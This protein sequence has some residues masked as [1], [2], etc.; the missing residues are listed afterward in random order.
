MFDRKEQPARAKRWIGE[1]S[2]KPSSREAKGESAG[3]GTAGRLLLCYPAVPRPDGEERAWAMGACHSAKARPQPTSPSVPDII[4]RRDRTLI[5]HQQAREVSCYGGGKARQVTALSAKA[6]TS[7]RDEKTKPEPQPRAPV[8]LNRSSTARPGLKKPEPQPRDLR[9]N[10]GTLGA[11]GQAAR[12]RTA[13]SVLPCLTGTLP[14][15]SRSITGHRWSCRS[16]PE[17]KRE[18]W[19]PA[20]TRI[21]LSSPRAVGGMRGWEISA[22]C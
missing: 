16:A 20:G 7:W 2:E 6:R 5:E 4:S 12:L 11:A 3:A 13:S 10:P 8:A 1:A 21:R 18:A 17:G 22:T 14:P 19:G 15:Q 9:P